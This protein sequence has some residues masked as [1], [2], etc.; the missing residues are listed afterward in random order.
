MTSEFRTP[1]IAE[2]IALIRTV[3]SELYEW[4]SVT[5]VA[6][7]FIKLSCA[8]IKGETFMRKK[9]VVGMPSC[10]ICPNKKLKADTSLAPTLRAAETNFE[11]LVKKKMCG[12]L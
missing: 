4:F 11:P 12:P 5:D 6:N 1:Q 10:G 3:Q 8:K 9:L 7:G 2:Q